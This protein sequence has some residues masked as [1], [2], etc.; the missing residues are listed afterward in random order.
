MHTGPSWNC[1][2]LQESTLSQSA[3]EVDTWHAEVSRMPNDEVTL[4]WIEELPG[5]SGIR[6]WN[7]PSG[8]P[9]VTPDYDIKVLGQVTATK[10]MSNGEGTIPYLLLGTG[11]GNLIAWRFD[12]A[13]VSTLH[14]KWNEPDHTLGPIPRNVGQGEPASRCSRSH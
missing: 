1:E 11:L 2:D 3:P 9:I 7:L 14:A 8:H 12:L 10:W 4:S 6:I 5:D 13:E